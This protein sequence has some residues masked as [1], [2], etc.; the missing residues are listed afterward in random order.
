MP[1]FLDFLFPF[2]QQKYQKDFHSTGFRHE[3]R[4]DEVDRGLAL[5]DLG[6]SGRTLQLCYSLKSVEPSKTGNKEWTIRQTALYHSF[7]MESDRAVWFIIKANQIE[8]FR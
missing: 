1:A 8:G 5:P 6:R 3:T 4:L 2:G 7:D